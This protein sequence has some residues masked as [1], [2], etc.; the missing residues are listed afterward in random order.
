M[1]PTLAA[2]SQNAGLLPS[3]SSWYMNPFF[4]ASFG[5]FA[6]LG[7]VMLVLAYF[8]LGRVRKGLPPPG[9]GDERCATCGLTGDMLAQLVP[10]K[11][12]EGIKVR[13]DSIDKWIANHEQENRD[14]AKRVNYLER[15]GYGRRDRSGE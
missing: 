4:L 14:L 10:C 11:A 5:A 3:A 13:V 6:A 2:A 15:S 8:I 7:F 1:E 12:H 9:N